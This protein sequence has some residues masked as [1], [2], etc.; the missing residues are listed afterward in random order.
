MRPSISV[1]EALCIFK[2][3]RQNFYNDGH[4]DIMINI[5]SSSFGSKHAMFTKFSVRPSI[6]ALEAVCISTL[7]G[8]KAYHDGHID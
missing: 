2:L 1:L 8:Q 7:R 5:Y 3:S 6:S 4:S